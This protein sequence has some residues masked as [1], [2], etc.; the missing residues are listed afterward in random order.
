MT[1]AAQDLQDWIGTDVHD[2]AGEKIGKLEEVYFRGDEPLAVTIRSGMTGRKHHAA[3]L[4]GATVHRDGLC[5]GIGAD[6]LIAT[7]GDG[8]G[9]DE[10]TALAGHDDRLRGLQ[11]DE[12]EGWSARE[13]R[14]QAQAEAKARADELEAEARKRGEE[15]E[16]AAARAHEAGDEADAA[17]D[18]R[19]EADVRAERARQEAEH[20]G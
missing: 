11:R 4:S 5:L 2:A 12:L 8:L 15:E 14:L 3:T 1:V 19:R 7:D 13:E 17:Q 6:A 10:L 9:A 18:A 16:A 20:A